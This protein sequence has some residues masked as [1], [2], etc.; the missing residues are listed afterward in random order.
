[1]KYKGLWRKG[2]K[3]IDVKFT[4]GN[5]VWY[6]QSGC[7]QWTPPLSN[8]TKDKFKKIFIDKGYIKT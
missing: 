3:W 8:C 6:N 5:R 7:L 4:D 2:N 1:M